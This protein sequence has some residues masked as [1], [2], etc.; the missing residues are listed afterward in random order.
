MARTPDRPPIGHYK[1]ALW[2]EHH[3]RQHGIV[4][5]EPPSIVLWFPSRHFPSVLE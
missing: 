1:A 2:D 5:F 3:R 4:D